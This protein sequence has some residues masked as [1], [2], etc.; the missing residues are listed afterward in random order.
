M[1]PILVSEA[2]SGRHWQIEKV[3]IDQRGGDYQRRYALRIP[4]LR[5]MQ[6]GQEIDWPFTEPYSQ[7]ANELMA[8]ALKV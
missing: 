5:N 8:A 3:D 2:E 6:T 7:I 1:Q 4:V